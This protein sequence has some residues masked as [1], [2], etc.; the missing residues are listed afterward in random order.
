MTNFADFAP[1]NPKGLDL[2]AIPS[3]NVQGGDLIEA[4]VTKKRKRSV[5]INGVR[6]MPIYKALDP[7]KLAHVFITLALSNKRAIAPKKGVANVRF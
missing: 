5:R 4:G 7:V 2:K 1:E 6:I 3:F